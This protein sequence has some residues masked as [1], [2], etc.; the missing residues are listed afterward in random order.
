MA[1]LGFTGLVVYPAGT[2]QSA[3]A[4]WLNETVVGYL[5]ASDYVPNPAHT[6]DDI[7]ASVLAVSA[8]PTALGARDTTIVA[9]ATTY[10][11][12]ATSLSF[13]APA[14]SFRY[15]LITA[16]VYL[17]STGGFVEEPVVALDLGAPTWADLGQPLATTSVWFFDQ[18]SGGAITVTAATGTNAAGLGQA[19]SQTEPS[20]PRL[21][22]RLRWSAQLSRLL[23]GLPRD[24]LTGEP[25]RIGLAG[26]ASLGLIPPGLDPAA[27]GLPALRT[28]PS[29]V[30]TLPTPALGQGRPYLP[31]YWA[32]PPSAVTAKQGPSDIHV[33]PNPDP[34]WDPQKNGW[35]IP[36]PLGGAGDIRW[37]ANTFPAGVG[38][39]WVG[40]ASSYDNTIG[41]DPVYDGW[42][43]APG[44]GSGGPSWRSYFP[45]RPAIMEHVYY[46]PGGQMATI[47]NA[48]RFNLQ[49]VE[50]M[51]LD[52][53]LVQPFTWIIAAIIMD[54]P[55]Y[56]THTLLDSGNAPSAGGLG[57]LLDT[58]LAGD[59]LINEDYGYRT[60]MV[61]NPNQ[62]G[63]A[64]P[65]ASGMILTP[66]NAAPKPRMFFG[67]WNGA[68]SYCGNYSTSGKFFAPGYLP[69]H[70]NAPLT[71]MGRANGHINR[72]L[73]SHLVV[74]EIRLF[75]SALVDRQLDDQYGQLSATWRFPAYG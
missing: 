47:T 74:F 42:A 49:F 30:I 27:L 1:S 32:T 2:T 26:T 68:G 37:T 44:P 46:G 75:N 15:L 58:Q 52:M 60:Q 29:Q 38:L 4:N 59:R 24:A 56:Y 17:Q 13:T 11:T 34:V 3:L 57:F 19:V 50:H 72:G 43:P 66:F 21:T 35:Y 48:M 14:E 73:A 55:G 7:M 64:N 12:A 40:D 62:M 70:G 69:N 65:P 33:I 39:H 28:L 54:F 67:C 8:T 9:G 16:Q 25:V 63:T 20:P 6:M 41:Q 51:W 18:A 10:G 31:P 5:L 45:Y 36:P 23:R 61:V 53:N 22:G 71:I